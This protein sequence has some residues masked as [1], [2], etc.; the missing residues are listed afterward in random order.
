MACYLLL[1][2]QPYFFFI[3]A[4][5]GIGNRF[6]KDKLEIPLPLHLILKRFY[7]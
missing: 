6:D 5:L 2:T 1:K 3:F 7:V 4:I